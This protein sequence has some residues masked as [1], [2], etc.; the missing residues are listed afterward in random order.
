MT[1]AQVPIALSAA[2]A[3]VLNP[4][5][6]HLRRN[7]NCEYKLQ[8]QASLLRFLNCWLARVCKRG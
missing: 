5:I 1:I 8:G 4:G 3:D 6:Y 2:R 7:P